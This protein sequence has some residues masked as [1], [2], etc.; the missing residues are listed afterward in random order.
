MASLGYFNETTQDWIHVC[1]GTV[2][3][4]RIIVTSA[5]C[6]MFGNSKNMTFSLK[7]GDEQINIV[8]ESDRFAR[9][10]EIESYKI[11]KKY[12]TYHYDIAVLLTNETVKFNALTQPLSLPTD[13]DDGSINGNAETVYFTGW[14]L[15]DTNSLNTCTSLSLANVT[16][17]NN[18]YCI[19]F[20]Y[21]LRDTDFCA[22]NPVSFV[23]Y[24]SIWN[25]M[26]ILCNFDFHA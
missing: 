2:V 1:S 23:L 12:H 21:T 8:E 7:T 22:G 19:T 6:I 9:I 5:N 15:G 3:S 11:H 16:I 10:Y 4:D 24:K 17:F 13:L 20:N 18:T 26:C 14:N 25:K